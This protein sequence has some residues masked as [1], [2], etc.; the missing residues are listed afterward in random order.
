MQPVL[1]HFASSDAVVSE[2]RTQAARRH[3]CRSACFLPDKKQ[4][5]NSVVSC[6]KVLPDDV[7]AVERVKSVVTVAW[8]R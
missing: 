7:L 5:R 1:S 4:Q 2:T 8:Q 3:G 6:R